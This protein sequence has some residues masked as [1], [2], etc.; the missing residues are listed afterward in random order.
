VLSVGRLSPGLSVDLMRTQK[1][2]VDGFGET[3]STRVEISTFGSPGYNCCGPINGSP[4]IV[5][6]TWNKT[7]NAPSIATVW[8]EAA[9]QLSDAENIFVSG[10]SLPQTDEFFKHSSH[11]VLWE[12]T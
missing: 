7:Q 9:N 6:P 10:Y 1:W 11:W 12:T 4:V 3:A 2:R 8:R 5:P